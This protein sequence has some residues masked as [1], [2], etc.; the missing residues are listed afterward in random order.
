[1]HKIDLSKYNLRTDLIIENNLHKVKNH[2]YKKDNIELGLKMHYIF[3][4]T[5]FIN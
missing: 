3:E 2:H 5:N 1:M 4:T